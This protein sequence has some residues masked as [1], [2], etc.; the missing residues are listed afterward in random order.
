MEPL[1]LK[2]A[3][4]EHAAK[5]GFD[6]CQIAPAIRPPHADAFLEWLQEGRAGEM[7]WLSKNA[8]RRTDPQLV[9]P[10][11]R[12]VI[13]V[14]KNYG[15]PVPPHQ[16]DS[17][18]HSPLPR[19][20]QY[21]LGDDYHDVLTPRLRAL[22]EILASHGGRQRSYIDTGPV[23]ERDFAA[24]SG[25]GWQG[26]STMLISQ[27]LGAFF[28]LGALLT[29]L[30]I[31]PDAPVPDRCGRCTRCMD[32]CP[33]AAITAPYQLD[34]RRCV[35]YLTIELKGSI[36]EEL[37][38]LLGD[39]IY[40]CDDCAAVCP[41]NRFAKASS[42][43]RFA[44]R[45]FASQWHLR[46]FLELD[47]AAFRQLFKGSPIKRIKRKGFLRNVCVALGNTGTLE[48][49]GPLQ[50]ATHDPEPLIAEH[51][52]WAVARIQARHSAF[53]PAEAPF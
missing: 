34:A 52:L 13:M 4:K 18:P 24:L 41:W 3:L 28:F 36:P 53:P 23:L 42:E 27:Q 46:D 7:A 31:P 20:A 2:H 30:E 40:G 38:P 12:S 51:A 11:A 17:S 8:D 35:S 33:T 21:A 37:R 16:A 5:L 1:A 32:V 26:K 48:D 6:A 22:E 44:A 25:L 10:G 47:E 50:K 29:T 19:I 45:P 39:R 49:L 15:R 14:A 9:L 43:A